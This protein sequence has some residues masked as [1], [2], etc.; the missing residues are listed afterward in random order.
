MKYEEW[1]MNVD[2]HRYMSTARRYMD[3]LLLISFKILLKIN[4]DLAKV[5]L[6]VKMIIVNQVSSLK[7]LTENR[8]P[9]P[10]CFLFSALHLHCPRALGNEV[11]IVCREKYKSVP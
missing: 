8:L 10:P 1:M 7:I 6:N 4:Y 9:S 3:A 5:V 2:F 11:A